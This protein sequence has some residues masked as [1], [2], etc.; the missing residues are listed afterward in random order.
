M[1]SKVYSGAVYGIDGYIGANVLMEIALAFY[2]EE[3]IYIW[4]PILPDAPYK[5]E[6]LSFGLTIIERDLQKIHI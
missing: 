6:L 5:E 1:L 2:F 3:K 4:N